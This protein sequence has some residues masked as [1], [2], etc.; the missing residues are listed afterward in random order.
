M[1]LPWMILASVSVP[2]VLIIAALLIVAVVYTDEAD[3]SWT[4]FFAI[5]NNLQYM[6]KLHKS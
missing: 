2:A 3:Q 1:M 4:I 5:G 6:Q